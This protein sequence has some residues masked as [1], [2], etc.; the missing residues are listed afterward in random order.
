MTEN[1]PEHR[2]NVKEDDALIGITNGIV[3]QPDGINVI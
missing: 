3:K 2:V 1:C